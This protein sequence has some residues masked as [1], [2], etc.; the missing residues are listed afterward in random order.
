MRYFSATSRRAKTYVVQ[1]YRLALAHGGVYIVAWVPVYDEFRTFAVERIERL[2]IKDETFRRTRDLPD[3]VFGA[4]M[5]VFSGPPEA[6]E[7]EFDAK[8]APYIRGRL[9]H[10]SQQID[11]RLDGRL[12]MKLRVSDDWALRSWLLGF[13]AAVRVVRPQALAEAI[14]SELA[15]ASAVYTK[16]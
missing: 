7:L 5:G 9:W 11:E 14:A 13:G 4:S 1:P 2:S 16:D 8:I 3:D 6:I 15:R 10:D 12:T